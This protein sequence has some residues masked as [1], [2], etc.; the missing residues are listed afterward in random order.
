LDPE[1]LREWRIG[2]LIAHLPGRMRRVINWLRRPSSRWARI[3]AGVL[4]VIGGV[5]S[6]LPVLGLW[7]LPVGL[8]LLAEDIPPLQRMTDRC[9]G[10]IERRRPHWFHHE[11]R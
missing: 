5:F 1:A 11:Q 3:P 4:F 7:M 8:V 2:Q 9:L 10:W 6:I